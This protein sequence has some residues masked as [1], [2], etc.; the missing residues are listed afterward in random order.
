MK[1]RIPVVTAITAISTAILL[2]GAVAFF[3]VETEYEGDQL[4]A[5]YFNEKQVYAADSLND[6]PYLFWKDSV[7]ALIYQ[8]CA[9]KVEK[10]E[11]SAADT[12]RFFGLCGDSNRS[13]SVSV[14]PPTI[15][16]QE[17]EGV[18]KI[19]AVSD[20][21]GEYDYLV[22]LLQNVG[23]IDD[24][25]RW[26]WGDGHLVINGDIFDRGRKVTECLWLIY[27]L[28]K[29]AAQAGGGVHYILGNHELM[30]LRGDLR[31]VHWKYL[32][33]TA[34]RTR[35]SY[36]DL[37]G[38]KS[39]MGRWLRTKNVMVKLDSLLFVHG[40]ISPEIIGRKLTMTDYNEYV[41]AHL[42]ERTYAY[43]LDS[44][45][46]FMFGSRSP[47]WYR[48][49]VK[50]YRFPRATDEQVD[51]VLEYFDVSAIVVGHTE[52]DSVTAFYDGRVFAIDIPTEDFHSLQGLLWEGGS[53]FRVT[54][55]GEREK[56]H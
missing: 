39:E 8:L 31:Y 4:L 32:D 41:R 48:A 13:F 1:M 40:G 14:T 43:R 47:F 17:I 56:L 33:K 23:V 22:S 18:G 30:V 36:D 24:S 44:L 25:C 51:S 42:D 45:Q 2:A 46:K 7:T 9:G 20:I 28:E 50:E 29:E 37:F 12:L 49:L 55:S 52:V 27:N 53:F 10:V 11:I 54:G 6:G 3:W 16:A 38:P 34:A 35:I 26:A 19:F 15:D 21:H 5:V